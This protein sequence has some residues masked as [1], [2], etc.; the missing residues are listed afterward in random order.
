[1]WQIPCEYGKMISQVHGLAFIFDC[2]VVFCVS[3]RCAN[4][5]P[6][7]EFGSVLIY[8]ICPDFENLS[9]RTLFHTQTY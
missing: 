7:F 3:A 8:Q 4:W 6:K 9:I 1:M 5:S 2:L